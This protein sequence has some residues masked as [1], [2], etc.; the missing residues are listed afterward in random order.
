MPLTRTGAALAALALALAACSSSPPAATTAA[1][2]SPGATP[3]ADA[4]QIALRFVACARAHGHRIPDPTLAGGRIRFE[5]PAQSGQPQL[6]EMKAVRNIPECEA[7]YRQIPDQHQRPKPPTAAEM[8]RG[9]KFAD[10]VRK[11][12]LPD[13]PDPSSNGT[14]PVRG[15]PLQPQVK[16]PAMRAAFDACTEYAVEFPFS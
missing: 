13:F 3:S 12:G 6:E 16:G 1:A 2:T 8:D 9:R 4:M 14:F 5:V 11:H 7:I 15:T 10:C